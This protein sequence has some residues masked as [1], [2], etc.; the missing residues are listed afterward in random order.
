MIDA[1]ERFCIGFNKM[2]ALQRFLHDKRGFIIII[3]PKNWHWQVRAHENL[4]DNLHFLL[5]VHH[6]KVQAQINVRSGMGVAVRLRAKEH[7]DK[8][9]ASVSQFLK[10]LF[11]YLKIPIR[12]HRL[13][14]RSISY[15]CP[16]LRLRRNCSR[17]IAFL[18]WFS[19]LS[20]IS[21]HGNFPA[22]WVIIGLDIIRKNGIFDSWKNQIPLNQESL[23]KKNQKGQSMSK[24]PKTIRTAL[25]KEARDWDRSIAK[26]SPTKVMQL[27]EAA[28]PFEISRPPRQPVSL[29]VDPFDLA[30]LK[31]L[32][33]QKGLPHTQLMAMWL[34]ER[35]EQEKRE[36]GE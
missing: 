23:P 34:H 28:E 5:L 20:N 14:S 4:V 11:H 22:F 10:T 30:M 7:R 16:L 9:L 36:D 18:N 12:F 27:I 19:I 17:M 35:I 26:E 29:R 33:R 32:A 21:R 15:R 24:L 31:R 2:Y 6:G 1:I 3:Q 13:L 8:D 25:S